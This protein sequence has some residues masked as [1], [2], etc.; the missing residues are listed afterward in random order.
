[1]VTYQILSEKTAANKLSAVYQLFVDNF[2]SFGWSYSEFL[3]NVQSGAQ[4]FC[5]VENQGVPVGA[6]QGSY[7]L[8]EGELL[9]IAV[10]PTMRQ[11]GLGG[12][13]L[14]LFF[15]TLKAHGVAK[16]FL[17]VRQGNQGAQRLYEKNGF[18][19]ISQRKNYYQNPT[20]NAWIYVKE[21][22]EAENE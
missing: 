3:H 15:T 5:Y 12:G 17:E 14:A 9:H 6:L 11:R 21:L 2:S 20:E 4:V 18:I 8:D 16:V 10:C 13:L 19:K 7:V 22:K 1:M